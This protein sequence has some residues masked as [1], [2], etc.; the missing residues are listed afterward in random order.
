MFQILAFSSEKLTEPVCWHWYIYSNT[1]FIYPIIIIFLKN[2]RL[3]DSCHLVKCRHYSESLDPRSS[4]LTSTLPSIEIRPLKLVKFEF[5]IL[6]CIT[7]IQLSLIIS[8]ITI[9]QKSD[10]DCAKY[11]CLELL[12]LR[13]SWPQLAGNSK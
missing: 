2:I 3:P 8:N 9:A 12:R 10:L 5:W 6:S 11:G 1:D 4:V 13:P 7:K